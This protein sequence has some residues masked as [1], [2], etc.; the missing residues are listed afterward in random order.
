[1]IVSVKSATEITFTYFLIFFQDWFHV[2]ICTNSH[3]LQVHQC[4]S[5]LTGFSKDTFEAAAPDVMLHCFFLTISSESY[6]F[7]LMSVHQAPARA[8][9][10]LWVNFLG[11]W[12]MAESPSAPEEVNEKKQRR[13]ERR[14]MKRFWC[15]RAY[16]AVFLYTQNLIYRW[17][18]THKLFLRKVMLKLIQI[19]GNS[20]SVFLHFLLI[21][22]LKFFPQIIELNLP[23]SDDVRLRISFVLQQS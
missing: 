18:W 3:P 21:P 14:Q 6:N 2:C 19:Y 23:H 17:W 4:C 1:M 15:C 22:L 10:L 20:F 11:P 9:Q 13:Q 16:G 8:L 7:I 5:C 12:F